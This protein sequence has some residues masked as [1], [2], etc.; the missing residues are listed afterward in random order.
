MRN[1]VRILPVFTLSA[2]ALLL[3]VS[4]AVAPQASAQSLGYEG[5]TGVFVT[6]L[7]YTA[8]SPAKGLGKP[9]VAYHLLNGGPRI[10]D[11][12]TI[13]VTEG[14]AQRFEFGYTSEVH[15]GSNTIYPAT[16]GAWDSGLS[17]LHAKANVIPE[18]AYKTKWVPAIS[19]G[20]I[21]RFNDQIGPK[22]N[23]ANGFT[24]EQKANN[25]DIYAVAT[26]TVTQ[27]C[28]KVPVLLTAG[29]RGTNAALWG[30]AGNTAGFQGKVFG[31]AAFVVKGP[32]KS[33]I[34]PAVEVSEQ[35]QHILIS[36]AGTHAAEF[37]VPTSEVYAVRIV[38]SPKYKLNL[39]AGVLHAGG[40]IGNA[41][42]IPFN[43]NMKA[44]IGLGISYGF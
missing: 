40:Q 35:P 32:Y 1:S 12:S 30:L 25:Y 33:T 38:P 19:V 24:N 11:Y 20:A 39:D 22:L 16:P 21:Y 36:G 43:L 23:R 42:S 18:N 17:I 41:N 4:L 8:A 28:P 5:P 29:I 2:A 34:I 9:S 7:A 44:R 26:K 37:D 10:G 14:F 6:P 13:S 27:I 15:A 3:L 31:S